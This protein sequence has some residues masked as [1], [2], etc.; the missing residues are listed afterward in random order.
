M[1]NDSHVDISLLKMLV[2][3]VDQVIARTRMM[4][5]LEPTT[6]S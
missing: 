5:I 1:S 6:Q 2:R 3:L 4:T